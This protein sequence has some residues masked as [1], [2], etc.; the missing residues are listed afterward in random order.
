MNNKFIE[1]EFTDTYLD[2]VNPITRF[3]E[4]K[5]RFSKEAKDKEQQKRDIIE[6]LI[7]SYIDEWLA[8]INYLASYNLSKTSGKVDFDPE[9]KQHEEEEREHKY[10]FINRL[11]ELN[12]E[13][14]KVPIDKW[15]DLNSRGT[16][17]KQ[18]FDYDSHKILLRR[19]EEEKQAIEF[20][21]LC[22]NYTKKTNDTTSHRLFKKVKEDEEKHLLELRD[23]AR[24]CG[25]YELNEE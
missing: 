7:I 17:W 11:R 18:E 20:Y 9:F 13:A 12:A 6:L 8:E 4:L 14:P 19:L 24:E 10:K 2:I 25:I 5:M 15:K 3:E 22:I 23:L 16:E 1:N 21:T